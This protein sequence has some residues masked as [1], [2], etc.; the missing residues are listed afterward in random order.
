[1]TDRQIVY[2]NFEV[3]LEV[4]GHIL[5]VISLSNLTKNSYKHSQ[6]T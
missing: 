2:N 4:V 3:I 5:D 1:M 6:D